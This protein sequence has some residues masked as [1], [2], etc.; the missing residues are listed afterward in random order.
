MGL[1]WWCPLVGVVGSPALVGWVLGEQLP[2]SLLVGGPELVEDF[3]LH[4][5]NVLMVA[6]WARSSL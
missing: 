6:I 4:G 2:V 1:A 3:V 5:C